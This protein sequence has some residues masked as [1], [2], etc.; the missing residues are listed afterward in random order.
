MFTSLDTFAGA[1]QDPLSMNRFL[2]A[3]ANPATL[4]DPSGHMVPTMDGGGSDPNTEAVCRYPCGPTISATDTVREAASHSVANRTYAA[5]V[6][7][8]V[9]PTLDPTRGMTEAAIACMRATPQYAGYCRTQGYGQGS[10]GGVDQMLA[11]FGG[12]CDATLCGAVDMAMHPDQAAVGLVIAAANG[13]SP[14]LVDLIAPDYS[15]RAQM[16]NLAARMNSSDPAESARAEGQVAG[17]VLALLLPFKGLRGAKALDPIASARAEVQ[18][19]AD[20]VKARG[21]VALTR[22]QELA[23]RNHRNLQ[24]AFEGYNFHQAVAR[25]LAD[26]FRYRY[27]GVDFVQHGTNIEIELTTAGRE[28]AHLA[29]Y[30][31]LTPDQIVTYA[32]P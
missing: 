6:M 27:R 7:A 10:P 9:T 25:E 4:I 12:V 24:A 14:G 19:A 13:L 16:T 5:T 21:P 1:A 32:L 30:P 28:A 15:I 8:P 31:L 18:A 29:R 17:M 22:P 23:V 3:E 2:Y 11:F 20:A 26:T